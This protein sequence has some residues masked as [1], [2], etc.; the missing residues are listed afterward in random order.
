MG[1][2]KAIFQIELDA[3]ISANVKKAKK[4]IDDAQKKIDKLNNTHIDIPV[5]DEGIKKASESIGDFNGKMDDM[6]SGVPIVGDSLSKLASSF[7]PV[8][9]AVAAVTALAIGAGKV[10]FDMA[11]EIHE[12][13]LVL[14]RFIDSSDDLER[15]NNNIRA[16]QETFDDIDTKE[17]SDA[18]KVLSKEFGINGAD[19][20][21]LVNKSLIATG[22]SMDL[23]QIKEYATQFRSMGATAEDFVGTVTQGNLEGFYNDKFPDA[24]KESRLRLAELTKGQ[25]DILKKIGL[26]PKKLQKDLKAGTLTFQDATIKIAKASKDLD[27]VTK[28]EVLANIFG[29]AGEDA[30]VR[31]LDVLAEGK[32][33]LGDMVKL[34]E[35]QNKIYK[36]NQKLTEA[37]AK[38]SRKLIK[39]TKAFDSI[40]RQVQV[41]L[42]DVGDGFSDI[43]ESVFLFVKS[44]EPMMILVKAQ[45]AFIVLQLKWVMKYI[46]FLINLI[47]GLV[48]LVK[49]GLSKAFEALKNVIKNVLG[50]DLVNSLSLA[51]NGFF[52][53]IGKR[54][55]YLQTAISA[56]VDMA[57]ALAAG[58]FANAKLLSEQAKNNFKAVFTGKIDATNEDLN[59]LFEAAKGGKTDKTKIADVTQVA[60][61]TGLKD[62]I[63]SNSTNA[64]KGATSNIKNITL[65][66]DALQH[67][68]KQ[69]V[70]EG[71]DV[72]NIEAMLQQAL[73]QVLNDTNQAVNM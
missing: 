66:L 30:G 22:G 46:G 24:L 70:N 12:V 37:Q 65:N 4:I 38:G 31:L 34:N 7:G 47:T 42:W 53:L 39:I 17:I 3:S 40:W 57:Q 49:L 8:G 9:M 44:I 21:E 33:E 10:M 68:E 25:G 2:K 20:V 41:V 27:Q 43:I 48:N 69:I 61:D 67:I 64:V 73:L 35:E 28:T 52:D 16:I 18:A 58:D 13:D 63:K 72:E 11:N 55:G 15:A 19:A 45:F 71:G 36:E 32:K 1:Q 54:F 62:Q 14:K 51:W 5:D 56:T 59:K 23:D 29:G 26:D 6:V 60:K 50:E